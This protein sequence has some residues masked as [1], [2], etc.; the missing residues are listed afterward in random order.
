ML[1]NIADDNLNYSFIGGR[2][3]AYVLFY[4]TIGAEELNKEVD[5]LRQYWNKK[6]AN[7]L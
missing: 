3:S 5:T 2:I 1:T 7:F 6:K 4:S